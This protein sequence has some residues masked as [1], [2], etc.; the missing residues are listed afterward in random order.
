MFTFMTVYSLLSE[1]VRMTEGKLADLQ[2]QFHMRE[3]ELQQYQ[4]RNTELQQTVQTLSV[5]REQC[6][7]AYRAVSSVVFY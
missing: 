3:N 4:N 7:E 1:Q 6:Y 2:N 5:E